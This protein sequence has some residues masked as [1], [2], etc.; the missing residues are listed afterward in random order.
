MKKIVF[1]FGYPGCGFTT[2]INEIFNRNEVLY[3]ALNLHGQNIFYYEPEFRSNE[4]PAY[5]MIERDRLKVFDEHIQNFI[6]SDIDVLMV[7]GGFN[8]YDEGGVCTLRH[9]AETFP[10]LERDIILL[11]PSDINVGYERLKNTDWFKSDPKE[12]PYKFQFDWYRF[13]REYMK[14]HLM[15]YVDFNYSFHEIDTLDGFRFVKPDNK[16]LGKINPDV[17]K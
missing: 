13:S 1:V 14:E 17:K 5:K 2:F 8:D 15:N 3:N 10:D 16:S 7:R 9:I 4:N 6:D 12:N 11:N